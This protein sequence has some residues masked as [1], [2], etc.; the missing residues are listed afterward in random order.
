MKRHIFIFILNLSYVTA[1]TYFPNNS[2]VKTTKS[3]YQAFTNAT[4]HVSPGN[5]INNATLLEKNGIIV[6]IGKNILLPKNTRVFD[7][8]GKHIYP[9]FIELYSEFGIK[10]NKISGMSGRNYQFEASRQGYYWNDHI[11]SDYNSIRDYKYDK[12]S[13]SKIRKMG[14]GIINT[15]KANGIHRGTG[16]LLTLNDFDNDSKRILSKKST[17]NY[18][19]KK[20]ITSNQNY[21]SSIMGSIALIRQFHHD[22]N[23]YNGGNPSSSDLSIEALIENKNLPKIF[24]SGGDKLNTIRA[25][26]LIKEIGGKF[27]V[28]GSGKE[29]ENLEYIKTQDVT[30]ILPLSFPKASNV[31]DQ[32]LTKQIPLSLMRYWSQAPSN[33]EKV[34]KFDI[35]FVFTSA[36]LKSS[37]EFFNNIKKAIDY[38]LNPEIALRALTVNPAKVLGMENK[39]GVL[40]TQSLANF[41]VTNGKLFEDE[42][43]ITENWVQGKPHIISNEDII[44]IDGDYEISINNEVFKLNIKES[45]KKLV[46]KI[47]KDST[48]LK[49]KSKYN[50]GWLDLTIIDESLNT[51]AQLNSKINYKTD[52]EGNGVNFNGNSFNWMAKQVKND[53]KTKNKS[54]KK[55]NNQFYKP[56]AITYPNNAFGNYLLPKQ[57]NMLFKNATVWTNEAEGIIYNTDVLVMDGKIKMIGKNISDPKNVEIIDAKGKHL[58][59]GIIDEHSHIGAS[60]INEG[61]H[62]SSAEVSI[63]DVLDPDDINIYRNLAGGVT[64]IQILHGSANPIGGQSA[65]INLKWGETSENMLYKKADPF[66]KFALGEN[67]KQSNW[68]SRSRFPQT[69]M[70]VEQVFIDYFQRAKEYGKAWTKYNMLSKK[71][72]LKT[73]IPR[74]DIEMEVLW[75]IL[76]GDRFISCHSYVQSEIN[77]LMKVAEK[78]NFKIN[79]FTH[80]LEGYKVSDKMKQHGVGASTFSDW[81]AYKFEVNDAIPYNGSI[82]HN[83]GVLVAYNSDSAEMS[84]RLNQEA[85]KAVKYGGVSEE[86]AWK[87]VTLNPAKMLHIDDKVGSIK[88]GKNADLVL[89]SDHPMSIYTKAEKT[90]IQGK[91]YFSSE[92]VSEKIKSIEKERNLLIGQMLD[93]ASKGAPVENPKK[94]VKREFH[95]ETLD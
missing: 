59:S 79:T 13:A 63:E 20:S 82:M 42:T 22:A 31:S 89:W 90:I 48:T 72:K 36:N 45:T 27:A 60:S 38:G 24:D 58:T 16:M 35:P 8:S 53:I 25:I 70:G 57:K 40:K 76:K 75:E 81:W 64:T 78:F 80:I 56:V 12:K 7:K 4:I 93:S 67:V 50:N 14:F 2:G 39:I 49:V 55:I 85:A 32:L 19:F 61:G 73:N 21:P 92:G 71:M 30:L 74:Y 88:I 66:I 23:W 69:R 26:K 5:V 91:I 65:I 62:N 86:D 28:L 77:M 95:C 87:F 68:G 47:S 17:E 34:A 51:F 83:A 9:S 3:I 54:T 94:T 18:S 41:I 37:E 6:K 33:P 29:Y 1:Q 84:R 44:N 15:H 46:A 10:K 52:F 43:I 11:L